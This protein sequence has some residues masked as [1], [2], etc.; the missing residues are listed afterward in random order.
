MITGT[1][2]NVIQQALLNRT[3]KVSLNNTWRMLHDS[4][5]IGRVRGRD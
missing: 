2:L 1:Q 4:E 3:K 5:A